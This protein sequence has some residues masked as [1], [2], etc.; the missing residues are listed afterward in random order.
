MALVL[1]WDEEDIIAAAA[2]GY[3]APHLHPKRER[4]R[5]AARAVLIQLSM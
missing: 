5:K 4:I 1:P 3:E 2:G